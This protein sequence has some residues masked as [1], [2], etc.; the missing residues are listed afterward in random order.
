MPTATV[1]SKGQ[2]TIPLEIRE[3][4]GIHAGTRVDFFVNENDVIEFA[5]ATRSV[6]ELAGVLKAYSSGPAATIEEMDDAIA[7]HL[8]E[9]HAP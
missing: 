5:P 6:R 3:R 9:K 8:S 7:A 2:I 4:F 1:S